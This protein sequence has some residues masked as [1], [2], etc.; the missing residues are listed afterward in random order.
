[1]SPRLEHS[2]PTARTIKSWS[3]LP[4]SYGLSEE[5]LEQH[6]RSELQVM[7]FVELRLRPNVHVQ[8]EE[9]VDLLQEPTAA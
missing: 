6:L 9:I 4:A 7:N 5:L 3:T 1:M 8:P 2:F